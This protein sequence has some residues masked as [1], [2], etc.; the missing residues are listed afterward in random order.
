LS[1]KHQF[2]SRLLLKYSVT[3]DLLSSQG[4]A[5]TNLS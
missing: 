4:S 2:A 3:C 5:A 1:S